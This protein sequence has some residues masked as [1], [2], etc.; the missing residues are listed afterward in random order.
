M[1]KESKGIEFTLL[2][3]WDGWDEHGVCDLYFYDVKLREAVFG[4]EFVEKYAGRK[5]DLGMWLE[6]SFVE[7]FV[8]DEEEPVL[9]K[10]VK[11]SFVEEY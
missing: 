4:K 2:E 9:T 7:I 3:S 6:S 1:S 10:K 11:L 8:E 5:V